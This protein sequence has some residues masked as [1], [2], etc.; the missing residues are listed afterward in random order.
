MMSQ[1]SFA[2][3]SKK[4]NILFVLADDLGIE[5]LKTYGGVGHRTPNIDKIAAQGMRFTHCFSN[6]FCSPSRASLLTGRYPFENGL[7][8]VLHSRRQEQLHLSPDQ[9]SFTRQ[10][11]AAGY[12]TGIAG[13]WHMS[14]LHKHNTINDFGFDQ[15]QVWQIFDKD[16]KKTKR[17]WQPHLNRNGTIIADDVKDRYGPDVDIEFLTNFM[18][19]SIEKK[20][21]FIAYFSTPLPHFPWEPTP[22]TP[23]TEDQSYRKPHNEHKGKPDYFPGMIRYLDK[24][25]GL[26]LQVLEDQGVADNTVVIFLSDNGT[27]RD[28]GNRWGDGREL[29]GGK[30]TMTDRGTHVPLMVS[31]PGH[32]KPNSICNDLIDFSDFL[33]TLCEIAGAPLPKQNIHGKSFV[34]QL[35]G[36]QGRSRDWVHVQHSRDRHV[37]TKEFIFNNKGQLRPVV[38]IWETP[39]KSREDKFSPK[40]RK[41]RETLKKAFDIL[42][43]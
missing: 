22:D 36:E 31:W 27:D 16:G 34:S 35:L 24:C 30:G 32:I 25:V 43:K 8:E 10:L 5:C 11:K 15:Y 20:K 18:A 9:P 19:K 2:A 12:A 17:F 6:P 37:R 33:P 40:E 29:K 23:D 42:G 28:L 1:A 14:L 39:A 26:L 3:P 7:K 4:P 38:Q 21:P 13:K 41:A